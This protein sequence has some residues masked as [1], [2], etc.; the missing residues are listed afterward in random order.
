MTLHPCLLE[1]AAAEVQAEAVS[2]AAGAQR[3]H[4]CANNNICAPQLYRVNRYTNPWAQSF[5]PA[6]IGN[7]LH[8]AVGTFRAAESREDL[9]A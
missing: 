5:R 8:L 1:R 6:R 7:C 4:S 9:W 2:Q 3:A